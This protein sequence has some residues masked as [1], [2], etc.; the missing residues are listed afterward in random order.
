MATE[1]AGLPRSV[2]TPEHPAPSRPLTAAAS[3]NAL[4]SLLDYIAKLAVGLVIVPIM[5][6]G[7]GRTLFGVW[8]MLNKLVGY[9]AAADGRPTQ[10]LRLVVAHG[11]TTADAETQRRQVGGAVVVWLLFLPLFATVGGTVIWLAPHITRV[12]EELHSTVRAA[13]GLLVGVLVFGTLA[14][15]PESV[16]R[17]M[18]LGY[19]RMGLQ[20]GL[21]ICGGIFTAAAVYAGLGLVGVAAAQVALGVLTGACF[22]LLVRKY[23]AWFGVSR[24]RWPEVHALF[25]MSLWLAAGDLI[26]KL[27]LASDVLIL[28]MVVSAAAVTSYVLTGYAARL[29]VN[30]HVLSTDGA[31]PGLAG[32]IGKGEYDRAASI[33]GELLALTWIFAT[34]AGATILMWNRSFLNLWVG[35]ENYAGFW[36]NLLIVVIALQTSFIRADAYILDAALRPRSRVQVGACSAAV[37]L[38]CAFGLT[39]SHGVI[40][41]CLGVL[42]GRGIQT[43]AYPWL[44]RASL[45]QRHAWHPRSVLRAGVVTALLYLGAGWVGQGLLARSWP[46]WIVGVALTAAVIL[47]VAFLAGLSGESRDAVIRRVK[48]IAAG[49]RGRMGRPS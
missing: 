18:N 41:L 6:S 15:I 17:G 33:R 3:L 44:V 11:R 9:L 43:V 39:R 5:L 10:A 32:V 14:A 29:A 16:L 40:G 19:R 13:C 2:P 22:W 48:A 20:A 42:A 21:S 25:G 38:V 36:P 46:I 12:P 37:T 49:R 4:Q 34:V 1:T 26:A 8:E 7:L 35:L 47:G 27:L 30:L 45:R 31:M 28:G 23:V 24:P